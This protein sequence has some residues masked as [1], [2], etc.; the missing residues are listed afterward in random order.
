MLAQE[1]SAQS[2]VR[3]PDNRHVDRTPVNNYKLV[4][5][6]KPSATA[7]K[8]TSATARWYTPF[9]LVSAL[10]GNVFDNATNLT[11]TAI[12]FDSTVLQRFSSGLNTINYSSVGQTID[13]ISNGNLF[14]DQTLFAGEVQVR[15][16]DAYRVDSVSVFASYIEEPARPASIVDT[17]IL[18]VSV[19]QL[20][21]RYIKSQLPATWNVAPYI[22]NNDT[23]WGIAPTSIDSV[24]RAAFSDDGTSPRAIWK[25]PLTDAMRDSADAAGNISLRNFVF[26]VPG[27]LNVAAGKRIAV[28]ATFK[29]GDTWVKNI[30]SV[31]RFHRFMPISGFVAANIAMPYYFYQFGDRNGSSLMFSTDTSFYAPVVAI[32][33]TNSPQFRQEFHGIGAFVS[34]STCAVVSVKERSGLIS[35]VNAFPNPASTLVTVP[36]VLKESASVNV[37]VTNAVG[38]VI[39]TRDM[40]KV[41]AGQSNK[42]VF[43]ISD[44]SN[45]IYFVTVEADGQRV[46]NRFVVAH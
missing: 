29:S 6:V 21:Y 27:G 43:S 12:W 16:T 8:T 1:V 2:I 4:M 36:F 25:V 42:A 19:N 13:V 24:N 45:G 17:L 26:A 33:A 37:N 3:L 39:Q 44:L 31:D 20:S 46:T 22:P 30:D 38:Q 40:G 15:S 32:E 5:P 7:N 14:N 35:Q 34:C 28:T 10:N 9:D 23:L 11:L 18:S 41:A